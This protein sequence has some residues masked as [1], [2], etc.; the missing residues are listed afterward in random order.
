[1][2][3]SWNKPVANRGLQRFVDLGEIVGIADVEG[4]IGADGLGL[5]A[6]IAFD[7]D[8]ANGGPSLRVAESSPGSRSCRSTAR[9]HLLR[10][11]PQTAL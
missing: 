4:E 6:L 5:D 9:S 2:R 10:A 7:A 3:T 11:G 8:G 1:M